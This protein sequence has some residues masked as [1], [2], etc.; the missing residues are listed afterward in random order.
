MKSIN[1]I[2]STNLPDLC[3]C[4]CTAKSSSDTRTALNLLT[5]CQ[6]RN[7]D[8]DILYVI[9]VAFALSSRTDFI[10]CHIIG[11]RLSLSVLRTAP[12]LGNVTVDWTIQGPLVRRTFT[13]TS[14]TLV[15]TEVNTSRMS[16]SSLLWIHS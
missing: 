5:C 11:E 7:M 9:I 15:F 14:G 1:V 6:S 2:I 4:L 3:L 10:M 13:Q 16:L 8:S 12:G